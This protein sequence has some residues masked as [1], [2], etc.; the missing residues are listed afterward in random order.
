MFKSEFASMQKLQLV[1][2]QYELLLGGLYGHVSL[3]PKRS[4]GTL[5]T[6]K[7][8]GLHGT[9]WVQASFWGSGDISLSMKDAKRG[10]ETRLE[11]LH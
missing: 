9:C 10:G 3:E 7:W 8:M 5:L 2:K 6:T 1:V 11:Q 4:Y